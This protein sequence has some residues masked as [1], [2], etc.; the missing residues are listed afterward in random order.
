MVAL[1]WQRQ[2]LLPWEARRWHERQAFYKDSMAFWTQFSKTE[3]YSCPAVVGWA[4]TWTG[5]VLEHEY[6]LFPAV[7]FHIFSLIMEKKRRRKSR[8]RKGRK[9][10]FFKHAMAWHGVLHLMNSS[11]ALTFS[12]TPFALLLYYIP[13]SISKF[14]S[15]ADRFGKKEGRVP[16]CL[17]P[18]SQHAHG[19]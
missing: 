3:L 13:H 7:L 14:I 11:A 4:E 12:A 9:R 16:L 18:T 8:K 15:W 5:A 10:V 19:G 1:Y 17:L 2:L 6:M